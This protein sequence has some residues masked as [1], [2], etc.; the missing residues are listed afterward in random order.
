M[1]ASGLRCRAKMAL[2]NTVSVMTAMISAL[3]RKLIFNLEVSNCLS[4]SQASA[5]GIA[6]GISTGK[7]RR[8]CHKDAELMTPIV[9]AAK[10][11]R[12]NMLIANSDQPSAES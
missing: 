10:L 9:H 8:P 4:E 5:V 3:A 6:N 2:S 11:I 1:T 7:R 12:E